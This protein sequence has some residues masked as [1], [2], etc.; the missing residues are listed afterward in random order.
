M[1]TLDAEDIVQH[2]N[3]AFLDAHRTEL[4]GGASEPLYRPAQSE[5]GLHQV[6]F[7][8]DYASSALHEV[9]HWCIAGRKRR[10]QEDYGYWYEPSRDAD[11]QAA[12]A[13]AEARPQA[14]ERILSHAANI[15]FRVS[16][17]NFDE[18]A[19]DRGEMIRQVHEATHQWLTSG[20]P[21]RA[22]RLVEMF[23]SKTGVTVSLDTCSYEEY[24]T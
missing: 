8:D 10:L 14:L 22:L 23:E 9:A 24:P 12:F 15:R 7:R 17:D 2:F 16:C 18:A 6:I 3:N 11:T 21:A 13:E 1:H 19:V 5:G 20:L 4:V